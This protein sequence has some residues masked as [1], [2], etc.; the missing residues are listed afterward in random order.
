MNDE[1]YINLFSPMIYPSPVCKFSTNPSLQES[2]NETSSIH[3]VTYNKKLYYSINCTL[4]LPMSKVKEKKHDVLVTLYPDVTDT[5]FNIQR[6]GTTLCF[7]IDLSQDT[8]SGNQ[9]CPYYLINGSNFRCLCDLPNNNNRSLKE[10]TLTNYFTT[11]EFIA[12]TTFSEN[13]RENHMCEKN[14]NLS[15]LIIIIEAAVI[16]ISWLVISA[17]CYTQRNYTIQREEEHNQYNAIEIQH[18]EDPNDGYM[19]PPEM[20]SGNIYQ[21]KPQKHFTYMNVFFIMNRRE[22]LKYII[23]F[24]FH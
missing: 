17:L 22:R 13:L 5:I 4:S 11:N 7:T 15:L 9:Q 19:T 8:V 24:S 2:Y 21:A 20:T 6:M 3:E 12:S 18:Q 14:A 1:L 16:I 10:S 23:F